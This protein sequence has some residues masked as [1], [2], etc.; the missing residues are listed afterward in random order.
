MELFGF[1]KTNT[2]KVSFKYVLQ[3]CKYVTLVIEVML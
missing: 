2:N 1:Y 3:I